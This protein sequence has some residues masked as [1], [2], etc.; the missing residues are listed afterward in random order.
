MLNYK[1]LTIVL[2]PL[3]QKLYT[4]QNFM[5][6]MDHSPSLSNLSLPRQCKGCHK[7]D[8]HIN[9]MGRVEVWFASTCVYDRV[10]YKQLVNSMDYKQKK[11]DNYA[12]IFHKLNTQITKNKLYFAIVQLECSFKQ[13]NGFKLWF[14]I[15]TPF[16]QNELRNQR[17]WIK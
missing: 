4:E 15:G 9:K 10:A 2:W 17:I 1:A 7:V 12:H 3:F 16:C 8:H 11:R 13:C 6:K 5:G 14:Y